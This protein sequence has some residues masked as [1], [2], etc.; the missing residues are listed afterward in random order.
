[1]TGT[2]K[3]KS[4]LFLVNP[5]AGCFDR[6]VI[7]DCIDGSCNED[8]RYRTILLDEYTDLEKEIK[9]FDPEMAVAVGGDGTINAVGTH[10]VGT[11]IIMG[12]LPCGS[13]NGL[14]K[15][16]YIPPEPGKAA[17]VLFDCHVKAIDTL[18]VDGK[19]CF[20]VCDLG[21]NA[22]VVRRAK[23][24]KVKGWFKYGLSL[25]REL[26]DMHF[27]HYGVSTAKVKLNDRAFAITITNTR[28]Y[29]NSA[30]I[31]PLGKVNDGLFEICI[32]KPFPKRALLNMI[33]RLFRRSIYRSHYCLFIRT[34]SAVITNTDSEAVH[35]DGDPVKPG[36]DFTIGILP[37]S[38][39]VAVPKGIN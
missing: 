12:I 21:F 18:I 3:P 6:S 30:A 2:F 37:R 8:I 19:Y 32:I 16:L 38:L 34:D 17:R 5:H 36:P 25:S 26:L 20:H 4:I 7:M 14:A 22:R 13:S 1:M 10:L 11:D 9:E 27:F 23:H 33:V 35:I 31:N 39:K 28:T 29:G 15:N 24:S